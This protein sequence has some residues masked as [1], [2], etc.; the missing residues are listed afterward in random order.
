MSRRLHGALPGA[1]I[2]CLMAAPGAAFARIECA[3]RGGDALPADAYAVPASRAWELQKLLLEHG[4]IRLDPAGDYRRATGITLRSGQAIFGAAGTRMGRLIV[5]PGTSG[6][7]LSGVIPEALEFPPSG[8]VTRDNCFERFTARAGAQSPL[9]LA[10]AFVHNN[11]FLDVGQLLIDTSRAGSVRNNRFIRTTVHG[12]YPAIQLL[13][14]DGGAGDRNVF[15]WTN[16]LSAAGDAVVIDRQAQANFIGLDAE[17]WNHSGLASRAAMLTATRSGTLR[18]FMA[19]G[20]VYK[21]ASNTFLD[22]AAERFELAGLRLYL[23][24]E[25]A[26]RVRAGTKQFTSTLASESRLRNESPESAGWTAYPEWNERVV[27]RAASNAVESPV[28]AWEPPEFSAIPDPAG[29]DWRL[30]RLQAPDSTAELQ[31]M[32][33]TRGIAVLPAGLF[34]ISAPLRLKS[35]QGIV[36]AGAG[37]T[38]IVAKSDDIDLVVGDDHVATP[39]PM[40]LVLIDITLQ[41]GRAGLRHDARGSG[42]AQYVYTQLSHVVFRDMSEAGI[43]IDGIYGWDN[44]LLD[45]LTFHRVPVGI[46]QKPNPHYISAE[47]SGNAPGTN[48]L[49]KNV[50]YRCRFEDVGTGLELIAKRANNLNACVSCRF[51][52]NRRSAIRLK[53][54]GST[55]IANSDFIDNQGD[56]VIA[57]DQ[58]V[59]IV[60]SRFLAAREGSLLDGD[61]LCESCDFRA[62]GGSRATIARA[63]ARVMLLNSKAANLRLGEGVSGLLADSRI[64]GS[65]VG[66][67]VQLVKG[68]PSVL[69]EGE[70]LPSAGLLV[71][72]GN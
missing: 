56:P 25:P 72:W 37:R 35:G 12:A 71:D 61:A 8:L 28:T 40:S 29:E 34:H 24:A 51:V 42:A 67:L 55:V 39:R 47:V 20:G 59:G 36:G 31:R 15:L 65:G 46:Q 60:A 11:L 68:E 3:N 18:V 57:S 6:A 23:T 44:N 62:P 53:Y 69:H 21:A 38:A 16:I 7:I 45:E 26:V 66:R 49:D 54:N 10:N 58:P 33:D 70:P 5:A 2:A 4:R 17:D 43:V 1:L 32:I 64:P 63:G 22:V 9:K 50:C 13:G 48:Y 41:G 30:K 19:Q 52:R 27:A 14:R